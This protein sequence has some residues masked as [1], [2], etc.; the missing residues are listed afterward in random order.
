MPDLPI[1]GTPLATLPLSDVDIIP[2]VQF[3]ETRHTTLDNL[4]ELAVGSLP[5]AALPLSGADKLLVSQLGV[6]KRVDVINLPQSVV[7]MQEAFDNGNTINVTGTDGLMI[8]SSNPAGNIL[9]SVTDNDGFVAINIDANDTYIDSQYDFQLHRNQV[10]F[11]PSWG[12]WGATSLF[13]WSAT[14]NS[15]R[16]GVSNLNAFDAIN[17]GRLTFGFGEDVIVTGEGSVALGAG[18][19]IAATSI[20][21]FASGQDSTITSSRCYSFGLGNYIHGITNN[22]SF[23]LGNTLTIDPTDNENV[24]L[25][26]QNITSADGSKN[27]FAWS[28]GTNGIMSIAKPNSFNIRASNECNLNTPLITTTASKMQF[29]P[30]PVSPAYFPCT[31]MFAIAFAAIQIGAPLTQSTTAFRLR[32]LTTADVDTLPIVGIAITAAAAAGD[33][34]E[35]CGA[36]VVTVRLDSVSTV[37]P[38]DPIEKSDTTKGRVQDTAISV[39]TFGVAC[40]AGNPNDFIKIWI[41]KSE[42]F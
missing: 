38:G 3:G 12:D 34:I 33:I 20:L 30:I 23:V 19:E 21:S 41:R 31:S 42:Q 29:G 25:M 10:G 26:G 7:G 15:F 32:Q 11:F 4:P 37:V 14:N 16:A 40:E 28:D 2:V 27:S 17:I 1:S 6:N 5:N 18:L 35:I 9:F 22:N 24:M 39:G 13:K 36:T 8:S